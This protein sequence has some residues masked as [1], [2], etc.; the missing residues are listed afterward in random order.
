MHAA[1]SS[2]T[3]APDA[4]TVDA[5]IGGLIIE[6][7][8]KGGVPQMPASNIE[9]TRVVL[10]MTTLRA[11]GDAAP[12]DLRT[13]RTDLDEMEWRDNLVPIPQLFP[14]APPGVY[15]MVD[16]RIADSPLSSVA[17]SINGRAAR[18]GNLIPFE[19]QN[20]TA[21]VGVAISINTVLTPRQYVTTT[22]ELDV[23]A[24]VQDID[25]DAVPLTTEGRMFIGDGDA[26]M[27]TVVSRLPTA[28]AQR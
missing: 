6:L 14:T 10:G 17:I 21:D 7:V 15:S 28:F 13:T 2:S 16:L 19:I 8:A 3:P 12:G 22:I 18:G 24:L 1:C 26:G 27:S 23:P 20:L 9:I 4:T 5:S 11:I 25:W